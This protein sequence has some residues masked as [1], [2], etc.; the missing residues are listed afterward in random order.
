M[1]PDGSNPTLLANTLG[2]ATTP[3]WT[4]NSRAIYFTNC[5]VSGVNPDCRILQG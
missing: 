1:N 5:T 2:R 3:R 4:S